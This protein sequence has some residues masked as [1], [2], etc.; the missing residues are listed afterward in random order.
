MKVNTRTLLLHSFEH[1]HGE[2]GIIVGIYEDYTCYVDVKSSQ[3]QY[4][5]KKLS[6][7]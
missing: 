7:D 3:Y 4:Y 5:L 1:L 6:L 2:C